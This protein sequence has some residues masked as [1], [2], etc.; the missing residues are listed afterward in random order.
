MRS[1]DQSPPAPFPVG[2][3]ATVVLVVVVVAEPS[4]AIS[5]PYRRFRC[6]VK[7]LPRASPSF[8]ISRQPCRIGSRCARSRLFANA[9]SSSA[10]SDWISRAHQRL[11]GSVLTLTPALSAP[12]TEHP[13]P[14]FSAHPAAKR[15]KRQRSRR[16]RGDP[17]G[18]HRPALR[19]RL[20]AGGGDQPGQRD[21]RV[22]AAIMSPGMWIYGCTATPN[23]LK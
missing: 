15:G 17:A 14:I 20:R 4:C 12:S 6:D 21:E 22:Q 23:Y 18:G 8:G 7:R 16:P 9:S 11:S 10:S 3:A 1:E 13:H 2:S 19:G 5:P